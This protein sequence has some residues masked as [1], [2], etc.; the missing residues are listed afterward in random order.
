M[1]RCGGLGGDIVAAGVGISLE[2]ILKISMEQLTSPLRIALVDDD[3]TT[4][5]VMERVAESMNA[6]LDVHLDGKSFLSSVAENEPDLVVIDLLLPLQSGFEVI[7]ELRRTRPDLPVL[8][9]SALVLEDGCLPAEHPACAANDY[10]PKP[11]GERRCRERIERLLVPGREDPSTSIRI[12]V[13]EDNDDN[14]DLIRIRFEREDFELHRAAD[15]MEALRMI[16][17]LEPDV[18]LLDIQIPG[19]GGLEVLAR[20]REK[21]PD[22][23]VVMMTA[24]G[25]EQI[26]VEAMKRGADDYLT[27]PLEHR[28]LVDFIGKSWERNR[29]RARNRRLRAQLELSNGELLRRHEALSQA[30]RQLEENQDALVRAQ[31][32][33]A[34]TETAVSINHEINN[35]LCSIMGNTDLLLRRQDLADHDCVRKLKSIERESLRIKDITQKLANLTDVLLTDYAGGVKMIDIESSPM[36]DPIDPDGDE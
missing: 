33:A 19:V 6:E 13:V 18:V 23:M 7:D 14:A 28:T 22:T 21:N 4:R 24:Y 29:M 15:G 30:L 34:V 16:D 10:L 32:L 17:D 3:S 9:V 2:P 1:S 35:P 36:R 5:A 11:V 25:S 20:L 26:A 27:K 31:R 12:L 8:V